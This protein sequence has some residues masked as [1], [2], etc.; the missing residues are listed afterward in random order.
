[1]ELCLE[2]W[3]LY[4]QHQLQ[5]L[6]QHFLQLEPHDLLRHRLLTIPAVRNIMSFI[7]RR[8]FLNE[9]EKFNKKKIVFKIIK[10]NIPATV[11]RVIVLQT[12][13]NFT[14]LCMSKKKL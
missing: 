12:Y 13:S 4:N 8:V 7:L 10:L 6:T 3:T 14:F 11:R 9:N 1:M 2:D 5:L